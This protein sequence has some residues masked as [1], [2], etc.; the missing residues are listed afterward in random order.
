MGP[1]ETL[2]EETSDLLLTMAESPAKDIVFD[3]YNEDLE[4]R[5]SADITNTPD[6]DLYTPSS[7]K[8][9]NHDLA[10][11]A[12]PRANSRSKAALLSL[13]EQVR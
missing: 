12:D 5:S 1:L 4:S 8:T 11:S 3:K 2:V 13:E 10:S 6:S 9:T 7:T